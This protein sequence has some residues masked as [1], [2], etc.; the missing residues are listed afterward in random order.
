[1]M[2]IGAVG[3]IL[4]YIY[5]G[6]S[7]DYKEQK[8]T[9]QRNE[10][11]E[12]VSS[13]KDELTKRINEGDSTIIEKVELSKTELLEQEKQFS[14]NASKERQKSTEQIIDKIDETSKNQGEKQDRILDKLEDLTSHTYKPLSQAIKQQII[15]N[16]SELKSKTK[17][18]PVLS[19]EIESGNSQR[20]KIALELE[21]MFSPLELGHYGKGNTFMGR[22]PDYPI[23]LFANIENL[24]YAEEIKGILSA[25]IKEGITIREDI[26]FPKNFLRIYING[27]PEF[28]TDGT[29]KVK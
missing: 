14:K 6:K 8:A 17:T 2:A 26:N 23:S 24:Q 11:S 9:E 12:K 28:Y 13:S 7:D 1:M 5:S 4:Y 16:L 27:N 25:Y 20:N 18:Y 22:F 10:I 29:I 15:K 19:I 3:G 21:S